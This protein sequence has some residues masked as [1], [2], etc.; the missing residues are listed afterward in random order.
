MSLRQLPEDVL[1]LISALAPTLIVASK[2]AWK[3]VKKQLG[4]A[5]CVGNLGMHEYVPYEN[6]RRLS[7]RVV[8]Y[9][10]HGCFLVCREYGVAMLRNVTKR[11]DHRLEPCSCKTWRHVVGEWYVGSLNTLRLFPMGFF[12]A[13]A[14]GTPHQV[15]H[16]NNRLL[17]M[18]V[19]PS[20]CGRFFLVLETG[21]SSSFEPTPHA[22]FL[23]RRLV[24]VQMLQSVT[25][26]Y[27]FDV[28]SRSSTYYGW[29][30][31]RNGEWGFDDVLPA[32]YRS[33]RGGGGVRGGG[34][35]WL[36]GYP[37]CAASGGLPFDPCVKSLPYSASF[38]GPDRVRRNVVVTERG[39]V[40][41][42]RG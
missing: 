6:G 25:L 41:G 2:V 34:V 8:G 21:E 17:V 42:E 40:W 24:K 3:S 10:K 16:A 23:Q 18:V 33:E 20:R 37:N 5:L 31:H 19:G 9:V 4:S 26:L 13:I 38:P 12:P 14:T 1:F 35:R 22:G 15:W 32:F 29:H 36:C 7:A 27:F 39:V 28:E 30:D 11:C